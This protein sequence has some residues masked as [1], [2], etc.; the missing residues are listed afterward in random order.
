MIYLEKL[1]QLFTFDRNTSKWIAKLGISKQS[2]DFAD[3]IVLD[4]NV[5]NNDLK[6]K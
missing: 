6:E 5:F 1:N 4:E 3:G 2:S